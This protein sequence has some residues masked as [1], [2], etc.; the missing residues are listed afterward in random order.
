MH[1]GQNRESKNINKA[2]ERK[3]GGILKFCRNRGNLYFAEIGGIYIFL[4]IGK[5]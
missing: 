1:H 2:I 4:E 3:E 5:I